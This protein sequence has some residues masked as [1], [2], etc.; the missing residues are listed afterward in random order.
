MPWMVS[1]NINAWLLART[2]LLAFTSCTASCTIDFCK[3]FCFCVVMIPLRRGFRLRRGYCGPVG[4]R[5]AEL[6]ISIK[7]YQRNKSESFRGKILLFRPPFPSRRFL[8]RMIRLRCGS[9]RRVASTRQ[10]GAPWPKGGGPICLTRLM[11]AVR[12]ALVKIL[13]HVS[14]YAGLR[15]VVKG[16]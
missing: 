15:V 12:K 5:E 10:G 9:A 1:R 2:I 7:D 4:G 3:W 6:R 16:F 11:A 14:S 8:V 13:S